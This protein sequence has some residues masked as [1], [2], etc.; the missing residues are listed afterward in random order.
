MRW[1]TDQ[2]LAFLQRRCD[3]SDRMMIASDILEGM[4]DGFR[5][6]HCRRCGAVQVVTG[7]CER[8]WRTPN[9]NPWRGR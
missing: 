7:K 9:P 6:R 2:I 3:H 1:L 5:V 4:G 8:G